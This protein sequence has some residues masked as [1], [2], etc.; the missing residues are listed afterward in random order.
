MATRKRRVR[1]QRGSRTCG[2]GTS[3]Q[4]RDGGMKGGRGKS[5]MR[6]HNWTYVIRYGLTRRKIGFSPINDINKKPPINIGELDSKVDKLIAQGL[7]E[8]KGQKIEIDLTKLG[9]EKLLGSGKISRPI[10]IKVMKCSENAA[11]KIEE[12]GGSIISISKE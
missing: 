12:A 4:H 2:W 6:K 1:K 9:Y 8:K 10:D 3:G 7:A 11:K 5:G